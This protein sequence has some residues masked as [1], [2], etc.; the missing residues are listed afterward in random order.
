MNNFTKCNNQKSD[1]VQQWRMVTKKWWSIDYRAN[2][3]RRFGR[4]LKERLNEAEKCFV[5]D[6]NYNDDDDSV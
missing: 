6:D 1:F 4:P 5:D 2:R 3:G